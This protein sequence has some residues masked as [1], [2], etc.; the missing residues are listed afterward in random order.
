VAVLR[1][2]VFATILTTRDLWT[3]PAFATLD[4][5]LRS[6]A[7]GTAWLAALPIS[8]AL[9]HAALIVAVAGAFAALVGL[10]TR[11][12]ALVTALALVYLLGIPQLYGTVRHYNHLVWLAGLLAAAPSG[13]ALSVDAWR[14]ARTGVEMPATGLAHGLTLRAAWAIAACIF[15][16]PGLWKLLEGGA[17]WFMS[18]NLIHQMRWKWLQHGRVSPLRLDLSPRLCHLAAFATVAFELG[19]PLLLLHRITRVLAL[20]GAL[21]FHALTAVVMFIGFGSLLCLYSSLVPWHRFL[22]A[23]GGVV[24][25]R[26]PRLRIAAA[27]LLVGAIA[28]QGARGRVQAWPFACYPTFQFLAPDHMPALE[29]T[30]VSPAGELVTL[31]QA[32]LRDV[33]AQRAWAMSWSLAVSARKG[34]ILAWLR[35]WAVTEPRLR[36]AAEIRVDR[37]LIAVDPRAWAEAPADR[38]RLV[39]WSGSK[40]LPAVK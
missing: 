5:Q 10:Y 24:D 17:A 21:L 26:V 29:V 39:T 22:R 18:D 34:P 25:R 40:P 37:V 28:V 13:D 15:F 32:H 33:D 12:A 35:A 23:R 2:A 16:F 8:A 3:A 20:A 6:P 30:A 1:I 4:G 36:D 27:L 19:F 31:S 38:V 9:A 14:R 7:V 11:A